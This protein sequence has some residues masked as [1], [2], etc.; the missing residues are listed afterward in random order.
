MLRSELAHV[1]VD[2]ALAAVEELLL[3]ALRF[4]LE[5]LSLQQQRSKQSCMQ[6]RLQ[7]S[8][9]EEVSYASSR[10][11]L[12]ELA[13]VAAA[14]ALTVVEDFLL[15]ALRSRWNISPCSNYGRSSQVC[16]GGF[17]AVRP[18]RFPHASSRVLLAEL[19]PV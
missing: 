6:W 4:P 1:A 2:V 11:L 10:V 17:K 14:V 18:R 16:S 3:P 13:P 8:P 12:A 7:G 19:A 15:P 5:A 9:P